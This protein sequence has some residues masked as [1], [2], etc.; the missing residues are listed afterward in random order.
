MLGCRQ[1]VEIPLINDWFS[2]EKRQT[3]GRKDAADPDAA[4][5]PEGYLDYYI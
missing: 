1:K 4:P 5:Q 2:I 3:T